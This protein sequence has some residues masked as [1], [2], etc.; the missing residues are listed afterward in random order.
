MWI[1]SLLIKTA[2]LIK[3]KKKRT[4][5]EEEWRD[6]KKCSLE[7]NMRET[8]SSR[9]LRQ[10]REE[11]ESERESKR[12]KYLKKNNKTGGKSGKLAAN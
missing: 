2:V 8:F 10:K 4:E 6:L 3:A 1:A 11:R 7:D 12:K 5:E 9:L